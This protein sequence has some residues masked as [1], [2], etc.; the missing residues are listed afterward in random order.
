MLSLVS[1]D[2]MPMVFEDSMWFLFVS[3]IGFS[4]RAL[5]AFFP[6]S[7][8]TGLRFLGAAIFDNLASYASDI[9]P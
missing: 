5:G 4:L 9:L 6:P 2:L 8:T 7:S 3:S 1:S